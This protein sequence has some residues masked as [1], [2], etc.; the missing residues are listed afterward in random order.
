MAVLPLGVYKN[1][2]RSRSSGHGSLVTNPTSIH[3][4]ASSIPGL[5]QWVKDPALPWTVVLV[6]NVAC[7][8][9]CCGCDC[10][11]GWQLQLQLDSSLGTSICHECGPE[12]TKKKKKIPLLQILISFVFPTQ[13]LF[14]F[15]F[16][17]CTHG[18]QKFPGQGSNPYH[19]SNSSHS[20]DNAGSL[21]HSQS[22]QGIS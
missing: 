11:C 16:F 1:F 2:R 4:G 14:F 5:A 6:T 9:S 7:V 21:T 13:F 10:G 3:E 18:M 12:K 20:S 22:Q 17:S 19:R 15:S 8:R